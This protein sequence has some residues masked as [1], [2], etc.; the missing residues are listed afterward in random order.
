MGFTLVE[1]MVVVAIIALLVGLILPAVQSARQAAMLNDSKINAK[2]IHMGMKSYEVKYDGKLWNGCPDNLSE[3][4]LSRTNPAASS[5]PAFL[6]SYTANKT[7]ENW[8]GA[9]AI[10][11]GGVQYVDQTLGVHF[12]S[13]GDDYSSAWAGQGVTDM[14]VPYTWS[15]GHPG[16]GDYEG[17]VRTPGNPFDAEDAGNGTWRWPNSYQMSLD[18][19]GPLAS[20]YWAPKDGA[21]IDLLKKHDCWS[22]AQ[23]MCSTIQDDIPWRGSGVIAGIGGEPGPMLGVPSTYAFSPAAMY[24]PKVYSR[25]GWRDPMSMA[26]GFKHNSLADAKYA[27]LKTFLCEHPHLQNIKFECAQPDAFAGTFMDPTDPEGFSYNGCSPYVFNS[28]YES[29]PVVAHF[30]GST[31]TLALSEAKQDEAIASK[32]NGGLG[33]FHTKTPDGRYCYMLHH[34]YWFDEGGSCG[35]HTHTVDGI[36]GR[37]HLANE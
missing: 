34:S 36:K 18:L 23:D 25:S 20:M 14:M 12:G 6:T 31:G 1:L 17:S 5:N 21:A 3:W 7:L 35:M 2:Q 29:E 16:Q 37:D 9:T 24:N 26:R 11:A 15:E 33:L 13:G 19:G 28:H 30:D 4:D 10:G 8:I 22:N 32:S 27:N